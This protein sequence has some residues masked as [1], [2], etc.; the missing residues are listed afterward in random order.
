MLICQ[1]EW[2]GKGSM[3]CWKRKADRTYK[4]LSIAL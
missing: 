2:M 4:H 1:L 3:W